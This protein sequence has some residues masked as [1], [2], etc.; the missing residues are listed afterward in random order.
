[1]KPLILW[2]VAL[3]LS[4]AASFV[5]VR[6][7]AASPEP[8]PSAP[9]EELSRLAALVAGLDSRQASLS[10]SVDEL[11]SLVDSGSRGDARVPVGE[12]EAA[13]TRALAARA[14]ANAD[15]ESGDAALAVGLPEAESAR[16]FFDKLLAEGLSDADAEALWKEAVEAGRLDEL[17]ALF[18]QRAQADPGSADKQLDLGRAYLQ[19]VFTAGNGPEAGTWATK[20]DKSFDAAL[21]ADDHHWEARF[22]KA[23]SLSFWPPVFGKQTEAIKHFELLIDQ[24]RSLASQPSHAQTWLLLGNMYQQLG[25]SDQALATWQQGLALFP[26]DRQ[27]AQQIANGQGH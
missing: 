18:E 6:F 11:R 22:S 23:V 7:A 13:V 16:G 5:V 26:D 15:E 17:L 1:M 21:A 3:L 25:K 14:S 8:A 9:S 10:K 20:A 24:Q 2:P 12:I 19:K 27:L 4:V